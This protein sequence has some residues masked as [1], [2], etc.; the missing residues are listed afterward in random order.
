MTPMIYFQFNQV[1][2]GR[3]VGIWPEREQLLHAAIEA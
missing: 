2:S 3:D 1:L